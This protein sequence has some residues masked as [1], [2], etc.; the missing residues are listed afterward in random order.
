MNYEYYTLQNKAELLIH[1]SRETGKV[2]KE[3]WDFLDIPGDFEFYDGNACPK[4]EQRTISYHS[5]AHLDMRNDTK[6]ILKEFYWP[7]N[8]R[9]ADLL[10]DSKFLWEDT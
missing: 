2:A 8:Q 10:G 9:L 3:L 5:D 7:F 1:L 4:N 6:T